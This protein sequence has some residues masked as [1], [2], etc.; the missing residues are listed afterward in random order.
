[1]PAEN[2]I[3]VY[4][5]SSQ[6]EQARSRLMDAGVPAS[7]IRLSAQSGGTET[8]PPQSTHPS[9]FWSWLFGIAPDEDRSWHQSNLREGRTALSV[10]VR[11]EDSSRIRDI[12]EEFDPID[13]DEAAAA[14]MTTG[15]SGQAGS[16]AGTAA[17]S[18]AIAR[19]DDEV[20]PIVREEL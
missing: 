18:P 12:L 4:P 8:A 10:H 7:D 2:L 3:A 13:I 14:R 15:I 17:S 1:M 6:A 9:D 5:S 16:P 11:N 20:I 19:K